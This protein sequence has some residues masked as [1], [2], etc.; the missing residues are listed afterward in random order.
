MQKSC[1]KDTEHNNTYFVNP[2][3]PSA[4]PGSSACTLTIKR[5]D[6]EI[7]QLKLDFIDLKLAPPD[8][9]GVCRVDFLSVTG[10]SSATPTICGENQGHHSE[11]IVF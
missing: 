2:G 1:G 6:S 4:D 8:Q 10:G 9:D 5:L 7:C 3:F 11:F